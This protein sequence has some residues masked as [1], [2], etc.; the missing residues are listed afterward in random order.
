MSSEK[1]SI[2]VIICAYTMDRWVDLQQAIQ[3][4]KGQSIRPEEIILVI[5]HNPML[6]SLAQNTIEGVCIIENREA[7]GLSGARNSGIAVA[8]AQVIAFMDEDAIAE[9][10]WIEHLVAG[11]KDKDVI[12]IGGQVKPIWPGSEPEWLP[13]EFGWVV[14]CTYKGLPT[15]N[16][17]IRNPIGCNMAFRRS[18]LNLAGGFRNGIGRVGTVPMGCEE[19]E[20]SIRIRQAIPGSKII[21]LP[22]AIVYHHVP[23]WRT[24]WSYFI[25]RCYSEGISKA[26][27]SSLVGAG[28]SLSSERQYVAKTLS[29]SVFKNLQDGIIHRELV[30]LKRAVAIMVGLSLTTA[31]FLTGIAA[32]TQVRWEELSAEPVAALQGISEVIPSNSDIKD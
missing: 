6:Y 8:T 24:H 3:S 16:S 18:V 22:E 20:L 28:D 27:I 2:S 1:L 21:Y 5:D 17:Q 14:G 12:G 10:V 29:S 15:S 25:N 9:P 23:A 11:F 4:V 13:E 19:T 31:G 26:T 7:K 30:Y 32:G